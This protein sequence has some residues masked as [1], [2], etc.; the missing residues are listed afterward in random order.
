MTDMRA[1]RMPSEKYTFVLIGRS[2]R[3]LR[4]VTVRLYGY[5]AEKKMTTEGEFEHDK[6]DFT[7]C[8][9]IRGGNGAKDRGRAAAGF[10]SVCAGGMDERSQRFLLL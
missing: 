6:P 3:K 5:T 2:F 9:K 7:G 4:Q 10:S 1:W 8:E